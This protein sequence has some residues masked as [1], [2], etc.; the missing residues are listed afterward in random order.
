MAI[1]SLSAITFF[2][3][4]IGRSTAFYEALGFEKVWGS[5][6]FVTLRA[7][8]GWVNLQVR[9]DIEWSW[10]GRVVF[11]VDDVDAHY[12]RV[13]AAGFVPEAAPVDAP[14]GERFFQVLDP[15]G[16]ELSF[17]KRLRRPRPE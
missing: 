8:S 5:P 3:H 1:E 6:E 17:A 2:T 11:H 15:D 9:N 10:W 4:D 12:Q 14:W 16:H 13:L 7:G